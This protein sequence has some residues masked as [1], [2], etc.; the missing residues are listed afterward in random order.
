MLTKLRLKNFKSFENSELTLGPLT[1]L[2]GTNASGKSN[3]RDALRLLQ[4]IA[5]GYTLTEIIS[6]KRGDSGELQW[7]GIRGG[8]KELIYQ[9]DTRFSLNISAESRTRRLDYNIEIQIDQQKTPEINLLTEL[10]AVDDQIVFNANGGHLPRIVSQPIENGSVFDLLHF[11]R[12]MRFL[13][14]NPEAMRLRSLTNHTTLGDQGENLASV[15]KAICVDSAKKQTLIEW[16]QALTPMDAQDF[17]FYTHPYTDEVLLLLIE[18]NGKKTSIYSA[19]DGTLRFLAMLAALFTPEPAPLYFFEEIENGI[20]PTRLHLLIELLEKKAAEG[21][22]IVATTHSPQ[23]LSLMNAETLKH[24]AL[25]YRLEE[26]LDSRIK[27]ILEIPEAK[28]VIEKQNISLL[29]ASGWFEDVMELL[30]QE[31]TE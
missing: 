10:M 12:A 31:A 22:Q 8:M 14:L 24:A 2:V 30:Q 9:Q 20:H 11:F 27:R 23:L 3:I 18:G 6:E 17:E 15:L 25:V 13:D 28:R 26:Q 21:I 5:R 19:S 29:H 16:I 4:G 7:S 1:L